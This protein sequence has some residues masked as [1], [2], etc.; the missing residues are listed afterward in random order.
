[1][2]EKRK[3]EK[4]LLADVESAEMSYSTRRNKERSELEK[5]AEEKPPAA[6]TAQFKKW[7]Q[8]ADAKDQAE[9]ALSALGY[10]PRKYGSDA[11]ELIVGGG[12]TPKALA[13]FDKATRDGRERLSELKRSYT[14]KLFAGGAEAQEL[15]NALAADISSLTN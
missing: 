13:D 8:A 11:P 5:E 1:M 7:M 4:L 6:A 3:L 12:T 10:R 14:L 9:E 2:E 15:F